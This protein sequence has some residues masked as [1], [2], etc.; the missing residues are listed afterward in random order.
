LPRPLF[1]L[2]LLTAAMSLIIF[3]VGMLD[4]GTA[5]FFLNVGGSVATLLHDVTLLFYARHFNPNQTP[6]FFPAA[7]SSFNIMFLGVCAFVYMAGFAMTVFSTVFLSR[8]DISWG[9]PADM[10]TIVAQDVL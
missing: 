10:G 6:I 4:L 5:G 3:I 2:T 9:T 8:G 1:F 7:A